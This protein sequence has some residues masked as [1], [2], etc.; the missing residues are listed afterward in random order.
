MNY[1]EAEAA[2]RELFGPKGGV[3]FRKQFGRL[4]RYH[5]GMCL[6]EKQFGVIGWG[7]SW[8]HALDDAKAAKDAAG[9][10]TDGDNDATT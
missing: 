2:A 1:D 7:D 8:E 4:H 5:V 10:K 3:R 9:R 6:S